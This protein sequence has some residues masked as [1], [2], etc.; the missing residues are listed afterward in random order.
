MRMD[1]PRVQRSI[2]MPSP[3][4][5]KKTMHSPGNRP[6]TTTTT[7]VIHPLHHETPPP[8]PPTDDH[9]TADGDDAVHDPRG[10][11]GEW[12]QQY[13]GAKIGES[14]QRNES[15]GGETA[16]QLRHVYT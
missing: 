10:A 15:I 7:A 11:Y 12:Q 1:R 2:R 8:P 9:L 5:N 6:T 4:P 16:W 3:S 14:Q 13:Y